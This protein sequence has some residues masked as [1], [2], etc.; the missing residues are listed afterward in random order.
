[1]PLLI[2][3]APG[4]KIVI[5]GVVVENGGE[6]AVLRVL[7]QAHLLRAKDI[8][9]YTEANTPARRIYYALQCLYLFPGDRAQYIAEAQGFMEDF[10]RAAP[11]SQQI[12]QD[13]A[14]SLDSGEHYQML[15]H[16]RKLVEHERRIMENVAPH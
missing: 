9:T 2:R 8:L 3:L 15:K 10:V 12:I 11:S 5:N 6:H 13:I 1:M 14:A 4:E 16:A 7:N